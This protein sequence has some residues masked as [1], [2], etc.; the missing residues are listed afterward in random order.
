MKPAKAKTYQ[1]RLVAWEVTKSCPLACKH[2]R[3]QAADAE[4]SGEFSTSEC[5]TLLD[6]IAS[7]A[8][9]I[10]ILTGGEP[11]AR[12]DIYDIIAYGDKLGLRMVMAPC[13]M[14][15]NR[16]NTLRMKEAGIQRISLSIDGADPETHDSFRQVDGAFESV[17]QAARVA[18]E[19]GLEFQINTT[20]T[21]LNYRQIDRILEL[22]LSIG[23]VGFH[24]FLLVPVGRGKDLADFA[25][26]P[27][28]YERIL[29]W[30]YEKNRE[31]EI[32]IKPTCAPHYYRIFRQREKEEG[33]TVSVESHGMDAMTKGCLGGQSFAFI[34]NT[35]R[36]QICGFL[37][38]E[39]GD[40]RKEGYR[41][42]KIWQESK[43]FLEVRDLDSYRGRCGICEY[44]R[45]C[46]GCRARA[47]A[48]TGDYLQEEP[49][50]V[51]E[52]LRMSREKV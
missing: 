7:F 14:L 32:P 13:G 47:F 46:G 23:A 34:S 45:F 31:V 33:R 19:V 27:E 35:G 12:E 38:E 51:Y 37:E 2:C 6:D 21:K 48:V 10:I 30:I 3:A 41:F 24:P 42:S 16:E 8:K 44:R 18:G 28:E 29:N 15:M 20:I 4:F 9:P 43:L 26:E 49:F 17:M 39:A 36:V 52:P 22:A 5:F 11:M 25:I 1:P 40:I 50:C